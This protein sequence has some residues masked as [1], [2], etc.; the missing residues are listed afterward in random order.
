MFFADLTFPS[1]FSLSFHFVEG[2]LYVSLG[3]KY[4]FTEDG[5][6]TLAPKEITK[7]TNYLTA[8]DYNDKYYDWLNFWWLF[9]SKDHDTWEIFD[10]NNVTIKLQSFYS[11]EVN[12]GIPLE[13]KIEK[14]KLRSKV[15]KLPYQNTNML[16]KDEN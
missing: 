11:E 8:R 2:E 3:H 1:Q 6:K 16:F 5:R 7:F 13:Y 4:L 9:L 14:P 10:Y 15:K 12:F